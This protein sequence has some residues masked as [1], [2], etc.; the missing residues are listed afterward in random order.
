[1]NIG[2]PHAVFFVDDTDAI[3]LAALGARLEHDALFPERA[4][5]NAATVNGDGGIR[6]RVWER[7]AGLT[8]ACGTGACA[9]LVAA[10]RRGM[11][12]RESEIELDGGILHVAW[13]ENG[14]VV[15]TGG[16]EIEGEG[17]VGETWGETGQVA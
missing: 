10:V 12:E 6:L 13:A 1:M 3:D 4:N 8:K 16:Y 15:M 17:V 7:G 2:N 11:V 14:H 5:I 9:T